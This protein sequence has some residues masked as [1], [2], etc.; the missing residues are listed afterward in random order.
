MKIFHFSARYIRIREKSLF[1][2]YNRAYKK[3]RAVRY[4]LN[5]SNIKNHE[6]IAAIKGLYKGYTHLG[7]KKYSKDNGNFLTY[8]YKSENI[9]NESKIVN[10]LIRKQVRR[11]WSKINNSLKG[12]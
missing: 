1:K 7:N 12:K 8:A 2:Y 10:N 11:H 9:F 6:K 5:S 3:V 4:Q